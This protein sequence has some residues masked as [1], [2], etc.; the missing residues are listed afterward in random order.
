MKTG[1]KY[2]TASKLKTSILHLRRASN[3][4]I[5]SKQREARQI[6]PLARVHLFTK[7]QNTMRVSLRLKK[8]KMAGH[9]KFKFKNKLRPKILLFLYPQN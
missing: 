3:Q 7:K 9:N 1:G 6:H 8:F 2:M 5:N 4:A